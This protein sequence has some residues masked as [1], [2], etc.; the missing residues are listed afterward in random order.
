[1]HVK[2]SRALPLKNSFQLRDTFQKQIR[3]KLKEEIEQSAT[4][5]AQLV[6]RWNRDTSESRT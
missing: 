2:L 3:F 1:M 4:F 6:W 5:E